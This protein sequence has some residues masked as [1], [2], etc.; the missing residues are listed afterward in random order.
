MTGYNEFV[1]FAIGAVTGVETY[2]V[3]RVLMTK[4]SELGHDTTTETLRD[5]ADAMRATAKRLTDLAKV[6]ERLADGDDPDDVFD[7][8]PADVRDAYKDWEERN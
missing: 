3:A 6:C 7:D 1:W 4:I 2:L 5:D 8:M